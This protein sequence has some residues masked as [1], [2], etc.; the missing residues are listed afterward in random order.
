MTPPTLNPA[1]FAVFALILI[2]VSVLVFLAPI[3]GSD[4]IPYLIK[5]ALALML[6]LILT[7]LVKVNPGLLPADLWGF[8]PLILGELFIG[9]SLTLILRLVLEGVQMAGQYIGFQMGFAIVNVINPQTGTQA[10]VL[11]QFA[12]ILALVIF[13]AVNGHYIVIKAL[14]QSFDLVPVGRPLLDSIVFREVSNAMAQ[15]FVI[16]IKIGAPALVVLFCV[17]VS[18]GIVAK[19][20]PQMNVLFVGMPLYIIIG[21]M[22]FG[23]SL[24]FFIPLLGRAVAQA[25]DAMTLVLKAM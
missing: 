17:K 11:S 15:M 10:S 6:A 7:P 18:M 2:R 20:V 12:Y 8:V 5:V 19:T 1:E 23:Y 4:L 9:L 22:V 16:A 14:M 13:L 25:G 3:F 21:L 24:Q